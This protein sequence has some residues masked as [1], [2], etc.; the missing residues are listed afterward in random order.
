M[1]WLFTNEQQL[2]AHEI[3]PELLASVL[4]A[5]LNAISMLSLILLEKLVERDELI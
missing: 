2:L 1:N 5:D 3:D 4:D